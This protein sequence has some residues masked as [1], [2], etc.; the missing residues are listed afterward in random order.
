MNLIKFIKKKKWL[1]LG[2]LVIGNFVIWLLSYLNSTTL[3]ILMYQAEFTILLIP[4]LFLAVLSVSRIKSKVW[5]FV[6]IELESMV[7][8]YL[9]MLLTIL[10]ACIIEPDP[11]GS[12]SDFL[13][14]LTFL[15]LPTFVLSP[16]WSALG[17]INAFLLKR[18]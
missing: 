10:T 7:F 3:E 15:L 1:I 17:I 12:N 8:F 4:A 6:L 14:M 11:V 18:D 2:N 5:T 9:M 13:G 16:I